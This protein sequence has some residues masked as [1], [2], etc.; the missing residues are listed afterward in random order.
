MDS[1]GNHAPLRS[2]LRR[3]F[4]T[5][6]SLPHGTESHLA[7]ALRATL[8]NPGSM[9]RAELA[10]RVACSFGMS[11]DRSEHLAIAIE[12]FHTASLL[13]D[14][15]PSM[16][17]AQMRRGIPCA[18]QTYGEGAAILGALAL[19]NRSYALIW[20]A[21]AGL[22]E[23]V[24]SSGLSYLERY[25][26]LAGLLN[27]QS[28]DL[29]YSHLSYN[30]REPQSIAMGKTVSLIRLALVLPAILGQ[31]SAEEV[32]LLDRLSVFWGLSYQTL[33]DLK[34]VLH[35]N[36]NHGK[37][38]ARDACLDRPNLALTIGVQES[39]DRI[40]R[41]MN[42][43]SRATARLARHRPRL[44]FLREVRVQFHKEISNLS[45]ASLTR[46]S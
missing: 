43:G 25:L 33:D 13:F 4:Q 31:A 37:T 41:L 39:F 12:Y 15:L 36:G 24:Q 17:D 38:A 3:A 26:G 9:V 42:L 30:T 46:A 45:E 28:H 29:H 7:G 10:Y 11:E 16:D 5:F 8:E 27:G 40:E 32:R 34:D 22:P 23:Q 19:I 35:I 44:A 14:D 20:K 21:V 2:R 1:S 18:H 6:L